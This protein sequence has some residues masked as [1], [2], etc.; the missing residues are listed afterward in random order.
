M[1]KND[2]TRNEDQIEQLINIRRVSKVVKGGRI[3]GF[4]ALTVV[5]D[6]K[7]RVGMGRGKARE[8]PLAVQK[9]MEAARRDMK[10]IRLKGTTIQYPV[11]ARH[12]GAKVVINPASDGTGIIAGGTM[13]AVFDAV[14][15]QDVLAKCIGSTNAV[16]VVRATMKALTSIEDPEDVATKRGKTVEEITE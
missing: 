11:V 6:G 2:E 16:N 3:F 15:I 5:G 9:A 7:G 8:V 14:G 13:R 12:S 1:A 10:R 4:S